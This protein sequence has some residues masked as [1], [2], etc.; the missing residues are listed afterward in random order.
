M[1]SKMSGRKPISVKVLMVLGQFS[2]VT[3]I[4]NSELV[5]A[6]SSNN[7]RPYVQWYVVVLLEVDSAANAT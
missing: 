2:P 5:R 4:N 3:L 6:H 1:F 7:Q